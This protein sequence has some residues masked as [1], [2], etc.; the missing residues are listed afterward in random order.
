MT[1]Q[2]QALEALSVQESKPNK[3][4]QYQ[5]PYFGLSL[6]DPQSSIKL[7]YITQ[8]SDRDFDNMS[9]LLELSGQDKL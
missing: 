5:Y 1:L 6:I 3:S 8:Y 7:L 9:G 4:V 2:S